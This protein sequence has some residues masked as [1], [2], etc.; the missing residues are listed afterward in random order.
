MAR[1]SVFSHSSDRLGEGVLDEQVAEELGGVALE[2][3]D[4]CLVVAAVEVS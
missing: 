4:R 1:S 3:L 2:L